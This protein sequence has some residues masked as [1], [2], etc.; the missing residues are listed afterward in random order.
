VKDATTSEQALDA[1]NVPTAS[2]IRKT[3]DIGTTQ[4]RQCQ[5]CTSVYDS[6]ERKKTIMSE[7][8]KIA[9]VAHA[10]RVDHMTVRR[11]ITQGTLE[12]VILPH[13]NER[14]SYRVKRSTLDK[15]LKV[16]QNGHE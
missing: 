2:S 14:A 15:I 12:A 11:W 5:Y 3:C 1:A 13:A 10:L 8:L 4:N 9:E 7:L 6:K 16:G